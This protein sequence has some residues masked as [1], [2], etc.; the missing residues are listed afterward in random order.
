MLDAAGG[1]HL[2]GAEDLAS[3]SGLFAAIVRS[4]SC[5]LLIDEIGRFFIKL[6]SPKAQSYLTDIMAYLQ[7]LTGSTKGPFLEKVRAEHANTEPRRVLDPNVCLFGT[8]VP[9]RLSQGIKRDDIS[10]GFL[11]RMLA[12]Q[13]DTPNPPKNGVTDRTPLPAI[14]EVVRAWVTRPVNA[15]PAGN[16]D[17]SVNPMFVD[18]TPDAQVVFDSFEAANN[19]RYAKTLRTGIDAMWGRADEHAMRLALIVACGRNFENPLIEQQ[20]AEWACELVEFLFNRMIMEIDDRMADNEHEGAVKGVL[21]FIADKG[22]VL[23]S[24]LMRKFRGL[25]VQ[26]LDGILS[27]LQQTGEVNQRVVAPEGGIGRPGIWLDHMAILSGKDA[28]K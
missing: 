23:K 10:D 3:D 16:L 19:V 8:T 25:K 12:F 27:T 13:S 7:R 6:N 9:G 1:I 4:P 20:D 2:I 26:A 22:S 11:P 28:K 15:D 24:E 17:L 21:K 14:V 18:V 5:L